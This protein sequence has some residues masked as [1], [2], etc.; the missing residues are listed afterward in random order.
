ME[1][2]SP[3]T[4]IRQQLIHAFEQEFSS[5]KDKFE[6][7]DLLGNGTPMD[8]ETIEYLKLPSDDYNI[9]WHPGVYAFIGNNSLYR[10][11]VSMHNSRAR[12]MQHLDACTTKDSYCI[13]DIDKFDDKSILLFNVK[14]KQDRHW[15]LALEAY[16][17]SKF[18]P[19]IKAG[20]IG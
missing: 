11:G 2:L 20:R 6:I 10:V 4:P 1:Q 17:E 7:I 5:I 18:I 19:F 15:L 14:S 13:W 12:V 3:T 9:V 16:L 8:C